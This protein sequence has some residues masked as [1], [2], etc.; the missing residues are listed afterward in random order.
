MK[1]LSEKVF[2][3]TG[4]FRADRAN[5]CPLKCVKEFKKMDRR[6]YQYFTSGSQIEL[7]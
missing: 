3:A 6:D 2:K 5:G 7:I 4:I 1:T